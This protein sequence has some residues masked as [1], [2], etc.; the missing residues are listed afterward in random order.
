MVG[1]NNPFNIRYMS[2]NNW[3][4]QALPPR[5]G[6]CQF[7]EFDFGLR[8]GFVLLRNYIRDGL[9]SVY[10]IIPKFAPPSE[11]DT[12]K[13]IDYVLSQFDSFGLS[14]FKITFNSNSFYVLCRA[15]LFYESHYQLTV[16][17]YKKIIYE[18]F[19]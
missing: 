6:F 19:R 1:R 9:D 13:Y 14:P 17:H 7:F 4:G 18:Y 3:Y 16:E 2:V 10:Q 12:N 11:N 15:I 8:A 5:K